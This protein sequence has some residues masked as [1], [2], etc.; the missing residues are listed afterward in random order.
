MVSPNWTLDLPGFPYQ[1]DDPDGFLP[2]DEIVQYLVD[3]A[4]AFRPPLHG[5]VEVRRVSR[6]ESGWLVET[7]DQRWVANDVIVA[8]GTYATPRIPAASRSLDP[9]IEQIHS[10]DY[11]RSA[12]LRAGGVMVI[13]SGQSGGQI[14]DD[15]LRAGRQVWISTGTAPW[16]PR[17]YR[18]H[19]IFW[20]LIE[21]GFFDVPIDLHPQG[22][23]VRFLPN[24]Q[25]SGF[26][27]GKDINLRAYARDGIRL[28]G[29]FAG[30]EGHRCRFDDDL[31]SNLDSADQFKDEV[32]ALIDRHISENGIDAD[33]DANLPV[34]WDPGDVPTE[35][36]LAEEDIST[37]IWATGYGSDFTMIEAGCFDD[38]G[39][40]I[41]HR[42]VT[43]E[44]GLYFVGLHWLHTRRS[45][46]FMGVGRDAEFVVDHILSRH[47]L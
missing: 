41:Q 23:A 11:R 27:G 29:R 12:D 4:A 44:S 32:T 47:S 26:G 14:A 20:W 39:Y 5:G 33:G 35:F 30:A 46:L 37:V 42:G 8:Q 21:I 38:T 13:G 2:R 15:L 31:V 17:R 19:D 6:T 18:G 24:P 1:G 9:S 45:G 43:T 7:D 40:P 16:I 25:L 3:Y 34:Q 22:T 28:L 36:D 10:S